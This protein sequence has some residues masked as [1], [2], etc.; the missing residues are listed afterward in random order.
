MALAA[1]ALRDVTGAL[2]TSVEVVDVTG[3]TNADLLRRGGAEGQVLVAESQTAGRGRM[4]RAWVSEPGASLTFSVL[5]RPVSVPAARRGWLPLLTGVAVAAAV[6]AATGV[7]AT[8]KWPNDVLVGERKLAG[9]LAEQSGDAVVVGIGVNVATQAGALPASPGG[10]RATSLLGEGA[11]VSREL[12]LAAILRGLERRYVAFRDDPDAARGGLLA[13]YRALSATLGR[14]VRV[15]LPGGKV[16]TGV[17]EDIDADGRLL[18]PPAAGEPPTAISAGDVIHVRSLRD[19]GGHLVVG[20]PIVPAG[21]RRPRIVL[22]DRPLVVVAGEPANRVQVR[23]PGDGREDDFAALVAAQQ[24]RAAEAADRFQVV[25]DVRFV[26]TLVLVGPS[27]R[28]PPAPDPRDH[29]FHHRAAPGRREFQFSI[30]CL[31]MARHGTGWR[32]LGARRPTMSGMAFDRS[33]TAG[34]APV[35]V[36]HPHWKILV[37]PIALTFLVVA[38]LLV[39]EVAIPAGRA[40]DGERLALAV[41]AIVL[42]MWWLI[43]PLL[44]WRTTVYELTTRRMSLR[45]G[46]IARNGRDIP[47]S[48]ITDISYRKGPLDRLLGTGTL[49]VESAGEHGQIRLTDIPDVERVQATL[50]QLVEDERARADHDDRPALGK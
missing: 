33:L 48:R 6:R 43:I 40:A 37:R 35:V 4:G 2:W 38:V 3:S 15:E 26:V 13:E 7:G 41:V 46:I 47:L 21:E 9:I 14:R 24:L 19:E 16:L 32:R 36:L 45:D 5:L 20:G 11:A 30:T 17:A 34:E 25:A 42:L 28:R 10:L 22:D 12:V 8:V 44:R 18:I 50:F 27:L 23:K 31:G 39:G 49:I 29:A 1:G